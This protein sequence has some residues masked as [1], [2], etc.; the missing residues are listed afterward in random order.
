MRTEL[1]R[2]IEQ[3]M[4]IGPVKTF[5]ERLEKALI[6]RIDAYCGSFHE[7]SRRLEEKWAARA[8]EGIQSGI[9]GADPESLPEQNPKGAA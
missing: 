6:E 7:A 4:A 2:L 3:E 1:R 8:I 9:I 5:A